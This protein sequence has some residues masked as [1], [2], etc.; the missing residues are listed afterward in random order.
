MAFTYVE[1]D[2]PLTSHCYLLPLLSYNFIWIIF[3]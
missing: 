2:L 1:A 3:T